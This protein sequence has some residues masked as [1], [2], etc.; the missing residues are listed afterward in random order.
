M[1]VADLGVEVG[2]IEAGRSAGDWDEHATATWLRRHLR[3]PGAET[4]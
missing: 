2:V 1:K 4:G 3:P